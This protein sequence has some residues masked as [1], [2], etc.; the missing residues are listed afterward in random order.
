MIQIISSEKVRKQFYQLLT[1][2]RAHFIRQ[3]TSSKFEHVKFEWTSDDQRCGT[4][5]HAEWYGTQYPCLTIFEWLQTANIKCLLE[6]S[7]FHII[8]QSPKADQTYL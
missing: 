5:V 6:K 4:A 2:A 7:E 8:A 3:E 1:S